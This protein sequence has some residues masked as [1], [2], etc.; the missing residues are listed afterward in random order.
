MNPGPKIC[1]L[2]SIFTNVSNDNVKG[3]ALNDEPTESYHLNL[4]HSELQLTG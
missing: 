4:L 2:I 1:P 3:F